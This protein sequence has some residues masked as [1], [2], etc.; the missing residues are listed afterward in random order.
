MADRTISKCEHALRHAAAGGWVIPLK[1]GGKTPAVKDW[2]A[3][4]T[5]DPAKITAHWSAY[6]NHNIGIY[7]GKFG[8]NEAL[9]AVDVDCKH[10]A[11]GY[12]TILAHEIEGRDLTPTYISTTPSGG[13]HILYRVPAAVKQGAHVLG[14][15]V[16]IRSAGGYIVAPG[17]EVEAGTYTIEDPRDPQP[18]P[19]WLVDMCGMPRAKADTPAPAFD[20]EPASAHARA[21][22]YLQ[23]DAAPAIEGQGGDQTTFATA[24]QLRDFGVS[25]A[26]CLNLMAE[27]WNPRCVPP[28][29]AAEL[30]VKVHNAFVYANNPAPG[31]AAPERD[32]APVPAAISSP[33]ANR[34]K[35]RAPWEFRI[36]SGH[37]ALVQDLLDRGGLSMLIGQPNTGKSFVAADIGL[38]I[39]GGRSWFNRTTRQGLVI[40]IAAEGGAEIEKRALASMVHYRMDIHRVPFRVID[41]APDFLTNGKD[42]GLIVAAVRN[43]E[44]ETGH[45]A[46]I[47]VADTLNQ[48]MAGGD[49]NSSRDMGA[50]V[51]HV[52]H[53][54][55]ELGAHVMLVHHLGKDGSRGAR[56]H[57]SLHAAVDTALEIDG[58]A[59]R[60]TKQRGRERGRPIGFQLVPVQVQINGETVQTLTPVPA[61]TNPARDF[62]RKP[63]RPGSHAERALRVLRGLMDTEG[64]TP[65]AADVVNGAPADGRV[66]AEETWR[67]ALFRGANW[68]PRG[69]R[70][71]PRLRR[72]FNRIRALLSK[73]RYI[74]FSEENL[75]VT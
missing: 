34:F 29:D 25:E 39:A 9:L 6:P 23:H 45:K 56:G 11:R 7:T 57:S 30:A 10:G 63:L 19:Q 73:E 52:K 44:A 35:V 31:S 13:K 32:F 8:D 21:V 18:A 48:T 60:V 42:A 15:G 14:P 22:H 47:L 51:R 46:A 5:R 69:K 24:A 66:I 16:D 28:W 36:K 58:G 75:W 43:A 68:G 3:W 12:E 2:Q 61:G 67:E 38:A 40:Y 49:E 1:P 70:D 64:K 41:D 62:A 20:Y 72:E 54:Q 17:S 55:H 65:T 53:I 59:I 33:A 37:D 26:T 50:Y 71:L 4:A 74:A 27:H